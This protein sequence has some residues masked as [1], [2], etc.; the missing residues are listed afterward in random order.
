[1]K[2]LYK[3]YRKPAKKL[4]KIFE[5]EK[6]EKLNED[7]KETVSRKGELKQQ[8][9]EINQTYTLY[10]DATKDAQPAPQKQEAPKEEEAKV[11]VA[12]QVQEQD[13]NSITLEEHEKRLDAA[14]KSAQKETKKR[15]QQEL[16]ARH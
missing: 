4:E 3:N 14:V 5:L 6:R 12:P 1:M 11:E 16:I 15:V 2:V 7:Q 13:D 10:L 8:V 9:K